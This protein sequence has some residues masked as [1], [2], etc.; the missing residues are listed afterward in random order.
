MNSSA[1]TGGQRNSAMQAF[2]DFFFFFFFFG[3]VFFGRY[4][5]VL[6]WH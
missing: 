1:G 4:A 2:V 3:F 5:V 6:S